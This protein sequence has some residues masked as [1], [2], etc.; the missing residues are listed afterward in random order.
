M[1]EKI[2]TDPAGKRVAEKVR[3]TREYRMSQYNSLIDAVFKR[4]GWTPDGCPTPGHLKEIGMDLPEVLDVV[5]A[6]MEGRA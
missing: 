6:R 3:I 4:R 5:N 2:L 1:E